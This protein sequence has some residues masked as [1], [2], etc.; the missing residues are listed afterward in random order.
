MEKGLGDLL[1]KKKRKETISRWVLKG[2]KEE[3]K[4][5]SVGEREKRSEGLSWEDSEQ[6]KYK[7]EEREGLFAFVSAERSEV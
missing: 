6:K 1:G 2:R 3:G 5:C 4:S 7:K